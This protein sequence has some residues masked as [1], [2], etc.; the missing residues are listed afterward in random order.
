MTLAHVVVDPASGGMSVYPITEPE[1][2]AVDIPLDLLH[3]LY[4]AQA[5]LQAAEY[6]IIHH[7]V[8]ENPNHPDLMSWQGAMR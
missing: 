3:G 8:R 1:S 2:D 7:L 5:A 6:A 4:R